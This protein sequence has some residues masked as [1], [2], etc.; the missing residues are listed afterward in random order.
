MIGRAAKDI[1][2]HIKGDD[3]GFQTA[4]KNSDSSM[5]KFTLKM[6][7]RAPLIGL[8]LATAA[9]GFVALSVKMAAAEEAVG[10]QTEALLKSQGMMWNTVSDDLNLYM[11]DLERLTA[12]NDT[13][14]QVAFNAMIAA[15]MSYTEAMESMNTVT[16][17]SY[18]LNRDLASMALLVGKAYNGQTG[19]LSRYGIVLDDTLSKTE[20]FAGLQEFVAENFADASDRT[21]SLEGQMQTLSNETSNFAEAIGTELIPAITEITAG[22]NSLGMS[23]QEVG[24]TLGRLAALPWTVPKGLVDHAQLMKEV[25]KLQEEGYDTESELIEKLGLHSSLLTDITDK[26]FEHAT[27]ILTAAGY[28]EKTLMLERSRAYG[29]ENILRL[30]KDITSAKI[31]Q[32]AETEKQLSLSQRAAQSQSSVL[33]NIGG[34]SSMSA[35]TAAL[36]KQTYGISVGADRINPNITSSTRSGV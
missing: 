21:D 14:L 6:Q 30:E 35:G 2:I 5:K 29:L 23:G 17:M 24:T 32:T 8:G 31:E 4:I 19:E 15:G 34:S 16:S 33:R 7:E 3:R 1:L 22:F 10:R 9:A 20:K 25:N 18:S 12:Y 27:N 28:Y 26:E 13:D 36:M 11:K